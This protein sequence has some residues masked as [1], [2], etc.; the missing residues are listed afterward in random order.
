ITGN[1]IIRGLR[2]KADRVS[3][4]RSMPKIKACAVLDDW[5][6]NGFDL[7]W[8]DPVTNQASVVSLKL[9]ASNSTPRINSAIAAMKTVPG[10]D[11]NEA[12]GFDKELVEDAYLAIGQLLAP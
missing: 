4:F 7:D 11:A 10:I 8:L 12:Q 9:E 2:A 6:M 1:R 3:M 5:G